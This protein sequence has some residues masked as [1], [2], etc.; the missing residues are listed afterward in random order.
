MEEIRCFLRRRKANVSLKH[1]GSTRTVSQMFCPLSRGEP[2]SSLGGSHA[3]IIVLLLLEGAQDI[4]H[5]PVSAT[6][7]GSTRADWTSASS[8]DDASP[9]LRES[10]SSGGRSRPRGTDDTGARFND[11]GTVARHRRCGGQRSAVDHPRLRFC[12]SHASVL[13][14]DVRLLRLPRIFLN[15]AH[16]W[17]I[18]A[19]IPHRN[20]MLRMSHWQLHGCSCLRGSV[21]MADNLWTTCCL[22]DVWARRCRG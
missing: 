14:A 20:K 19:I 10:L 4:K 22:K 17:C 2:S 1:D 15:N 16:T 13:N 8:L 18:G 5:L 21:K 9:L 11:N 6:L 3:F 7:R 12:S